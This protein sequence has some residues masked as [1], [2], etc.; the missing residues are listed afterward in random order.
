M[1]TFSE[2]LGD[3]HSACDDL[4]ARAEQAVGESRWP[5]AKS[6]HAEFVAAMERHFG[7][8]EQALFPAFE[9][10]TGSDMGPTQ[11]MRYEHGQMREL[12]AAMDAAAAAEDVEEYLGNGETL[13]I[14]MQQHNAKE[15]QMLYPMTDRVL[16]ADRASL[17][18][19]MEAI[20]SVV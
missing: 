2:F 14:M 12:F 18:E 1:H 6:A 3:D 16:G 9:Q 11:V 17:F 7:M 19:R 10:A 5:D 20:R 4:Y 8:E 13:L 15:E